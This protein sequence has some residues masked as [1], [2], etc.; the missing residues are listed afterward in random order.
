[1]LQNA[2]AT[3]KAG[4]ADVTFTDRWSVDLGGERVTAVFF[5]AAHTG[6]DA[7]VVFERA[8]VVHLGDLVFNRLPP[9][10]DRA[11]GA[12][13]RNWIRVLEA[14]LREHPGAE[15]IFGHG[16]R[17]AIAGSATDVANFRGYLGAVLGHV[18]RG[19][20][21]GR[22]LE[23]IARIDAL[24]GFSEYSDV[25]KNYP[26]AFPRFTL[27]HVLTAAHQELTGA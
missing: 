4:L 11:A 16:N 2:D 22:S 9:F 13:I 15:F 25:L 20:A 12:S 1:M 24:P 3:A 23:E 14:V 26:S 19:I 10:V 7:V 8:N 17:D 27:S 21:A 5:G 18:E 6:G